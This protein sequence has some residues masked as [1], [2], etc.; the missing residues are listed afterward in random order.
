MLDSALGN[1]LHIDMPRP[2]D[3]DE[4]GGARRASALPLWP[5]DAAIELFHQQPTMGAIRFSDAASYVEEL[6]DEI[7]TQALN[8]ARTEPIA[9]GAFKLHDMDQWTSPAASLVTARA[10]RLV[11]SMLN[12]ERLSPQA[13]SAIVVPRGRA[14][15]AR[16][17]TGSGASA[18]MLLA[19]SGL[20]LQHERIGGLAVQ[21]PH[22]APG[23]MLAHPSTM[24]PCVRENIALQPVV[25]MAW[26][27]SLE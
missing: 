2:P 6:R 19:G 24:R 1:I 21:A 15:P 3:R 12:S 10:H 13:A 23:L 7:E 20:Y 11:M 14:L 17:V 25:I 8:R 18:V 5:E 4:T 26:D 16:A 27:Y 22:E 9:G